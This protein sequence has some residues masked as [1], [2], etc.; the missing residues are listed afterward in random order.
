MADT[1]INLNKSRKAREKAQRQAQ[2]D[3]N[4]ATFGL[5]KVLRDA[6]R[7]EVERANPVKDRHQRDPE[8]SKDAATP[9]VTPF[10]APRPRS[11]DG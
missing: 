3:Q 2:A 7:A 1:P 10:R 11:D 4:A 5:P 6:A 8:T 9:V